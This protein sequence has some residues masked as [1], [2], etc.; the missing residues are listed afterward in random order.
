[1]N[2]AY[3][4]QNSSL[5]LIRQT[6]IDKQDRKQGLVTRYNKELSMY[7]MSFNFSVHIERMPNCLAHESHTLRMKP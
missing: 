5:T 7:T 3:E 2:K 1:M 6:L 4:K